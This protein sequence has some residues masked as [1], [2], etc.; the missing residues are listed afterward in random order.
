[1]KFA[2]KVKVGKDRWIIILIFLIW[3]SSERGY[4]AEPLRCSSEISQ[5]AP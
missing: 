1:M 4:Q 2:G 3:V 5:T